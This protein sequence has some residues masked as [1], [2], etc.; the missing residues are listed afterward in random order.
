MNQ[1]LVPL[2]LCAGFLSI[3]CARRTLQN[4]RGFFAL[5]EHLLLFFFW[6]LFGVFRLVIFI[7]EGNLWE[8]LS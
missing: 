6:P 2:Y 5:G 3:V 8:N 1:L 7:I 4:G